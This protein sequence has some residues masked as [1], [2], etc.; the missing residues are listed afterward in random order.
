MRRHG[1]VSSGPVSSGPIGLDPTAIGLVALGGAAGCL[2]RFAIDRLSN[3]DLLLA[4]GFPWPTLVINLA[5]CLVIGVV[6]VLIAG[7]P[8]E[9]RWRALLVTGLLGGF[10]T[11]SAFALETVVLADSGRLLAAAVYLSATLFVGALAVRLG[12]LLATRYLIRRRRS[13]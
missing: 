4:P 10:T 2:T 3:W 5:G 12:A 6:A 11:F 7:R 1:P 13:T 9:A 8:G